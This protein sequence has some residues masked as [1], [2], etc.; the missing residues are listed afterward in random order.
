LPL[1][2]FRNPIEIAVTM[3]ELVYDTSGSRIRFLGVIIL[4]TYSA[5]PPD[6]KKKITGKLTIAM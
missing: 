6:A 4:C 5:Y 3:Q 2:P 1:I